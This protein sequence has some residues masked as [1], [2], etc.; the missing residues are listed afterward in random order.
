[1]IIKY[2][3]SNGVLVVKIVYTGIEFYDIK[4]LC[5]E[6]QVQ[7]DENYEKIIILQK[8]YLNTVKVENLLEN[9]ILLWM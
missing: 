5:F 4:I 3:I 7:C 9:G 2:V 1:M 8:K 6:N